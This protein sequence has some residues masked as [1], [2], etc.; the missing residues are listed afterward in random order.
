MS[1]YCL[2]CCSTADLSKEYLEK[3]DVKYA[4]FHFEL[5]GKDHLDD[6]WQS[7]SP[8]DL[9]D[10]ML[11]GASAKTSQ[12]PMVEYEE[13]FESILKEGK[14]ILHLSLSSGLSGSCSS[15]KVVAEELKER[16]PDRKIYVVDSLAASSG[17]GLFVDTLADMRDEGMDIDTLF[18]WA[19]AHKLNMH[20]WFF[21]S[22]LTFYIRGGRVS[23]AS[24][25][26]GT[27]LGICPLLNVNNTGHLI[28]REKVR[29]KKRAIQRVVDKMAEHA[30]NGTEYSG[31]CF[32]SHSLI[33]EDAQK[34][35]ELIEKT[36]PN[37]AEKPKCFP[38]GATVGAHSGPGTIAVFFWGD[39]RGE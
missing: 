35:V 17:Y 11:A 9:Y 23:K 4:C 19:E 10:Q 39:K 34:V 22:D 18:N 13:F 12:I 5:D 36:F 37:L 30:D 16:Y 15:A 2:T 26:I 24:G 1:N 14:D 27:I 7:M 38:I 28:P 25:T 31:K 21:S 33:D 32:V 29:S 8:K 20:H 3:R 6:M